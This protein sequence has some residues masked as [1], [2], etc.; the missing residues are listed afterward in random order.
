VGDKSSNEKLK[1]ARKTTSKKQKNFLGKYDAPKSSE[2]FDSYQE[3]LLL[4][5]FPIF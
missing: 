3:S 4:Y 2:R 1:N 5:Y